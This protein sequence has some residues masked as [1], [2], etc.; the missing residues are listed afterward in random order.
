MGEPAQFKYEWEQ[1]MTSK[2][3]DEDCQKIE[4]EAMYSE[5]KRL[6]AENERLRKKMP[7]PAEWAEDE[8]T[9]LR[10][11]IDQ[12]KKHIQLHLDDVEKL[13]SENKNLFETNGDLANMIGKLQNENFALAADQCHDGYAGEYGHHMCREVEELKAEIEYW[14]DFVP[15]TIK[16]NFPFKVHDEKTQGEQDR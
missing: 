9:Q 7:R 16:V 11:Q 6:R 10:A 1:I 13:R 4:I 5:V 12:Y 15:A 3:T 14:K 8:V 2:Y